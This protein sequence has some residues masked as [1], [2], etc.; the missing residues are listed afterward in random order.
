MHL[1]RLVADGPAWSAWKVDVALV[2]MMPINGLLKRA[3]EKGAR[4]LPVHSVAMPTSMS[5]TFIGHLP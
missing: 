5:S 1:H 4:Q 3:I 2:Y